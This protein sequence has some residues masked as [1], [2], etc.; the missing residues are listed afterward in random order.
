MW[1]AYCWAGQIEQDLK[2]CFIYLFFILKITASFAVLFSDF[3]LPY[4]PDCESLFHSVAGF[5]T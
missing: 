5:A 2:S 4:F 3:Y 1:S